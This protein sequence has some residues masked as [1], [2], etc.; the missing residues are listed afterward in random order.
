MRWIPLPTPCRPSSARTA[1]RA[2]HH[3]R[4]RPARR[5]AE[6]EAALVPVGVQAEFVQRLLAAGLPVVEDDQLRAPKWV[7]QLADAAELI[8]A[9]RRGG[10]GL[11][12][13]LVPSEARPG[14]RARAGCRRVAIFGSATGTFA[15][16]NLQPQPRRAVRRVRAHACAGPAT[17]G[18]TSAPTSRCS[19]GDPWEVRGPDR[20]GGLG[21][22]A[23]LRPR[24]QP[25]Q[26]RRHDRRR[27]DRPRHR[28]GQGVHRRRDGRRPARHAL[29]RHLRAGAPPNAH[30]ALQARH[31]DVRRQRPVAWR[32]PYARDARRQPP[33]PRTCVDAHR[34]G[35]P[36]T[37]WTSARSCR[38]AFWM[39]RQLGRP[40]LGRREG[41]G[42]IHPCTPRGGYLRVG[43]PR[44]GRPPPGPALGQPHDP[45]G[46]R[47][48]LPTI[49]AGEPRTPRTSAR[50]STCSARTGVARPVTPRAAGT[51]WCG[52]SAGA[53][54]RSSSV[55]RSSRPRRRPT[56]RRRWRTSAATSHVVYAR[57]GT[58]AGC[59]RRRERESIEQGR[60]WSFQALPGPRSRRSRTWIR[61]VLRPPQRARRTWGSGELP[62]G[63]PCGHPVPSR[64]PGETSRS[65]PLPAAAHV[66]GSSA[67]TRQWAPLES[68][69]GSPLARD[70]QE[71]QVLRRSSA[72]VDR[73]A[74][75][76][77]AGTMKLIRGDA[78][79]GRGLVKR[80]STPYHA[81][82]RAATDGCRRT[83]RALDPSGSRGSGS[84]RRQR[85]RGPAPGRPGAG[86]PL[87]RPDKVSAK[88]QLSPAPRRARRDDQE[89]AR[90]RTPTP[91]RS[92]CGAQVQRVRDR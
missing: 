48:A 31:H 19:F 88:R 25:A 34:S 64:A 82:R 13:M 8:G 56:W 24:R 84:P 3:L 23:A 62:P 85:P 22:A 69:G 18:S 72:G 17:R 39:A 77:V 60:G 16:Q 30:A 10:P 65:D 54:A 7:P 70:H 89:A 79:P 41:A 57:R 80:K 47:G 87:A 51:R 50:R 92:R 14:P 40:A 86:R 37:A 66:R 29:P 59:C 9:P 5:P 35:H 76:R 55:T 12:P 45:G 36:S 33:P 73:P 26:P 15:Q 67:S 42:R 20:A 21:R 90:R 71:T 83:G 52:G 81:A 38:P 4:G 49:A 58:S 91:A 61:A 1:C 2:R 75:R 74:S 63:G 11:V 44:P 78:G 46:A 6:R 27:H 53:Q 32:L 28:P 68:T 43:A